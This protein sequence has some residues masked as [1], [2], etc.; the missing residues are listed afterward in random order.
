MNVIRHG[1][2]HMAIVNNTDPNH[3]VMCPQPVPRGMSDPLQYAP[4]QPARLFPAFEDR[5]ANIDVS[6][7]ESLKYLHNTIDQTLD[8]LVFVGANDAVLGRSI[9]VESIALE[10]SDVETVMFKQYLVIGMFTADLEFL[11]KF[12]GHQGASSKYFCM[13]CT[14]VKKQCE[15]VFHN[16]G[17]ETNIEQ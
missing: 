13:F 2:I 4:P 5:V 1:K 14:A 9:F 10:D 16:A 8:G 6:R 7:I 12:L 11:S 17:K 15:E 3:D